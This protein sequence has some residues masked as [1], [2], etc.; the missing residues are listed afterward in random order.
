VNQQH[1][2]SLEGS[3]LKITDRILIGLLCISCFPTG[4]ARAADRCV[5]ADYFTDVWCE[6]CTVTTA[7]LDSL[8]EEYP[9]SQLAVIRYHYQDGSPF[10]RLPSEDRADYYNIWLI[11]RSYI[12]GILVAGTSSA[13]QR[14]KDTIEDRLAVPSP[15]EMTLGAA[16]DSL[17][18]GGQIFVEVQAV[19]SVGG[20]DLRLRVGLI[21]SGLV[22]EE[23]HHQEILMDMFPDAEGIS[24]EIESG[25]V[26]RDTVEF[27]LYEFLT[28]EDCSEI[29]TLEIACVAYVQDDDDREVLQSI[30][31]PLELPPAVK[32]T[33]LTV[34]KSGGQLSLAWSPVTR[35]LSCRPVSIDHYLIYRYT[36]LY[37]S[38]AAVLFDSTAASA[39]QDSACV[40]D[41]SENCFYYL[42]I[43]S[44]EAASL[45]SEVVGEIDHFIYYGK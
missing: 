7:A 24:F 26:Y 18:W 6:P 40:G 13:Y 2:H 32:V 19:D 36:G 25:E 23:K 4:W 12:D 17:V 3:V 44:S 38:P 31:M 27:D 30:Q 45:P 39:Y 1:S 29:D 22:H 9:D 28:P 43:R 5:L 11:P 42:H 37:Y 8:T 15:L 10:Y 14:Y 16:Y 41:I 20:Q 33:D 34:T 21:E 35:D